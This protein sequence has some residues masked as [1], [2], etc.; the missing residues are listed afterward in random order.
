MAIKCANRRKGSEEYGSS[1]EVQADA[2]QRRVGGR[3]PEVR[4]YLCCHVYAYFHA[5]ILLLLALQEIKTR[6]SHLQHQQHAKQ[7]CFLSL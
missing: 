5:S 6:G 2:E 7:G 3:A 1:L 4:V